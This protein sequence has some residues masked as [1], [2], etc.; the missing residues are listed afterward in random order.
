MALGFLMMAS[1]FLPWLAAPLDP[2]SAWRVPALVLID[3]NA[4]SGGVA[5]G[6]VLAALGA[7]VVLTAWFRWGR[8]AR[9]VLGGLA[10]LVVGAFVIQ[11]TRSLGGAATPEL[12]VEHLGSGVYS[13]LIGALVLVAMDAR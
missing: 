1:A 3:L 2:P 11:F 6:W 13:G 9:V 5:L 8:Y 4:D 12:V 10:L 7:L